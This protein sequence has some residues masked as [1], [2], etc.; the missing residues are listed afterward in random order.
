M[1]KADNEKLWPIFKPIL[2]Q[3][4][5]PRWYLIA[6]GVVAGMVAAA[7]AGFGLPF[8][9]QYVFPIV[10]G[11]EE[12]PVLL[13]N[14]IST[15]VEPSEMEQAVMWI[16]AAFIP[17]VM[18]IRGFSTYANTYL[19]TRAG[20]EALLDLR[21][22]VF[23]RLQWLSFSY[24]DRRTRGDLMTLVIQYT[25]MAQQGMVTILNELVIQPLTLVA[26][27]A[28]LVYA[29]C[30]NDESAILLGN[31]LISCAIVPVVRGVGKRMAKQMKKALKDMKKRRSVSILGF[32]E[33]MQVR[34]VK[35]MPVNFVMKTWCRQQGKL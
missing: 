10:F 8:M 9:T 21:V 22:D 5:Q 34:L 4:I 24:H 31:L 30:S 3:Y 20:T 33:R 28:Y 14:W 11:T 23:A 17:L 27:G 6:G 12:M 29:A 25:Q 7:S 18:A 1:S 15:W 32:P 13:Q 19:L 35:F 2:K 16:A 26:A